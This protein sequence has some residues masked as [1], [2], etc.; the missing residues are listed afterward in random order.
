MKKPPKPYDGKKHRI[1]V[2]SAA[3]VIIVCVFAATRMRI[4]CLYHLIKVLTEDKILVHR[5]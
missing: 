3:I 2:I 5:S 1:I 4:L